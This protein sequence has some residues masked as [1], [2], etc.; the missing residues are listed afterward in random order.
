MKKSP[1]GFKTLLASVSVLASFSVQADLPLTIEDLLTAQQ[2]WRAELGVVY[3]NSND[4]RV[5]TGQFIP[6]Q[7]GPTQFVMI[8]STV[9]EQ[10]HSSDTLVLTPGLRYGWS[11][12]TELFSR[13]SFVS[14]STRSQNSEGFHSKTEDRFA[15][16]WFGVNHR[17]IKEGD[18]PALLGFAEIALAENVASTDTDLVHGRSGLVGLTT[19]RAIDPVVLVANVA[20]R[21]HSQRWSDEQLH[22]PGDLF[23]INPSISFAVN[24]EITLTGGLNWRWQRPEQRDDVAQGLRTTQTHLTFGLGHSWSQRLTLNVNSRA[25]ISGPASADI[26]FN[27]LYKLGELPKKE[28]KKAKEVKHQDQKQG[29][30]EDVEKQK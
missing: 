9:G 3:A 27:L 23:L 1:T 6:I 16:A 29:N 13:F 10:R 28:R 7:T 12:N 15:D 24:N 11:G 8:P 26:D 21:W 4:T 14:S 2:R 19:Y 22:D 17:F 18:T 30:T 5:E 20:Y 25:N